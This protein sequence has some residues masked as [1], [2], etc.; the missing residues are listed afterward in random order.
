MTA[1]AIGFVILSAIIDIFANMMIVK[2]RGFSYV[3]WGLGAILLV[4]IAFAL[5]GQAVR[6]MDL[7]VAYAMWGA[8]GVTG[9]A[10]LGRIFFGHKLKPLG[11][12]GIAAITLA[13]IILS[14]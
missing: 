11:W 5:L 7:A 1:S 13:V 9:T 12:F 3:K 6:T 10:A 14:L 2:S 8:I 4:W